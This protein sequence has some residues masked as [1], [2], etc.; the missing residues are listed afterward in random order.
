MRNQKENK[1]KIYKVYKK[2]TGIFNNTSK[3]STKNEVTTTRTQ[4]IKIEK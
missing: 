1:H 4:K 2:Y 3:D